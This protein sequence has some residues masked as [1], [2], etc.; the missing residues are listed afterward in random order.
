MIITREIY[1]PIIAN[2]TKY[3]GKGAISKIVVQ[4]LD[5]HS[6]IVAKKVGMDINKEINPYSLFVYCEREGIENHEVVELLKCVK[7]VVAIAESS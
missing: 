7:T 2:Y 1:A 4:Q 3:I 5:K 6:R